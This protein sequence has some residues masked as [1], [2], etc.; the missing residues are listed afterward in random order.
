MPASQEPN[1][2]FRTNSTKKGRAARALAGSG[3]C[4]LRRGSAGPV[5]V[6]TASNEA[7]YWLTF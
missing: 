1:T 7:P 2:G 5:S 3:G 6:T 4:V